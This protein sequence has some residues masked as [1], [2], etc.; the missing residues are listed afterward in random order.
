MAMTAAVKDELSRVDVP[1]PC[2]RRAEMA[3]LLRVAGGR[4]IVSGRGVGEAEW[5]PDG[6]RIIFQSH[7]SN[8]DRGAPHI[9]V[10]NSDGTGRCRLTS[11][12]GGA[13]PDVSPDGRRIAFLIARPKWSDP[14]TWGL[15]VMDA[16]GR[17]QR[18]LVGGRGAA[19]W[20]P[21]WSPDGRMI[22]F[23]ASSGTADSL[24]VVNGDGTGLTRLER[25]RNLNTA[26][27]SPRR[28]TLA[29]D[30]IYTDSDSLTIADLRR[31]LGRPV[32]RP[33]NTIRG[34]WGG[35]YEWS[36]D[37]RS[38]TDARGQAR[39]RRVAVQALPWTWSPDR[40]WMVFA[41][42]R[43][44]FIQVATASGRERRVLTR[45][46]KNCCPIDEIEWAPR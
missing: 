8:T 6:R 12:S 40:R 19:T 34:I 4:H 33:V 24:F 32:L 46:I 18:R 23:V 37:G 29:M 13:L 43:Q 14:R 44:R 41:S 3:A 30:H 31:H 16:S 36:P 22:M 39:R 26:A 9:Y 45:K 38:I 11:A 25:K 20:G 10:I 28:R 42:V 15:Y 35:E 1:K 2:C 17:H 27:W 7:P 21:S 5:M